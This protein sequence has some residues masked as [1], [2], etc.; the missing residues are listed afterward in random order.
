MA[1]AADVRLH[2]A[3]GVFDA[4]SLTG[5][6]GEGSYQ[7]AKLL[8]ASLRESPFVAGIETERFDGSQAGVLRFEIT[9]VLAPHTLF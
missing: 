2:L 3:G 1:T 9:M 5:K 8:L 7:R 4:G 6:H